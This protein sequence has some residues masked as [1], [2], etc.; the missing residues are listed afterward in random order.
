MVSSLAAQLAKGASLNTNALVEGSRRKATESYLFTGR[1]ADQHDLDTLHALSFNAF[2][3]LRSL[4]PSLHEYE[5]QLFSDAARAT[6][7]TLLTQDEV[8]RLD[9]TID[10]L[11]PLLGPYL[12]EGP[13]GKVLEWLVRRFRINEFNVDGVLALFLP[14]HE[15]P[16][17]AKMLSILHIKPNSMWSFLI[18][19]QSAAQPVPRPPLVT[20][21]LKRENSDARRFIIGLLP[22]AI[23]RNYVHHTLLAFNA[24]TLHD[25]LVRGKSVDEGTLAHLLPAL[26]E[27]LQNR[28][29]AVGRDAILGSY[30]LLS[31]LSQ[32]CKLQPQALRTIVHLMSNCA[33]RVET[34]QFVNAVISVCD[35][36]DQLDT[37][38]ETTCKNVLKLPNIDE[39]LRIAEKWAGIDKFYNPLIS[40]ACTRLEADESAYSVLE[41]IVGSPTVPTTSVGHLTALLLGKAVESTES[42][43]PVRRLLSHIAQIHPD[44]LKAI[45]DAQDDQEQ[46]DNLILTLSAPQTS[47]LLQSDEGNV[48]DSLSADERVRAAAVKELLKT[49][50][51]KELED[52]DLNSLYAALLTRVQDNSQTVLKALY[53]DEGV[54]SVM[55]R[56]ALSDPQSYITNL[57]LALQ[58][59]PKRQTLQLQMR[60]LSLVTPRYG[61]PFQED[62]FHR[63]VFPF[64]LFSKTRQHSAEVV[65]SSTANAFELLKGCDAVKQR[66]QEAETGQDNKMERINQAIAIKL[67]ENIIASNHFSTHLNA[68]TRKLQDSDPHVRVLAYLIV[69]ELLP[70]LEGKHQI[71]AA[72]QVI[73]A[74]NVQKLPELDESKLQGQ[75]IEEYLSD[76]NLHRMA[77]H[78]TTSKT[79]THWLQVSALALIPTISRPADQTIDWFAEDADTLPALYVKLQRVVYKAT[80]STS[81]LPHVTI[82]LLSLLF[83]HLKDDALAFLAGLCVTD[84]DVDGAI[85]VVALRHALAFLQAHKAE[86]DGVD[87]QTIVP[88]LIVCLQHPVAAVRIATL[89]CVEILNGLAE[90]KFSTVYA[91]D[92]IYGTESE[93]Q[94]Q[95]LSQA[96]LKRYLAALVDHKDH[97]MLDAGFVQVFHSQHLKR[98]TADKRKE[99]EYKQRILCYLLSHVSVLGLL[100]M[101]ISLLESL[102]DVSDSARTEVIAELLASLGDGGVAIPVGTPM[103]RFAALALSS[104]DASA[105]SNLNDT[106]STLWDIFVSALKR[107]LQSDGYSPA[108]RTMLLA[109][110]ERNLLA[111]LSIDRKLVVCTLLLDA[112]IAD[113]DMY[114]P[115]KRVLAIAFSDISLVHRLLTSI[116]PNAASSP[117]ASKRVKLTEPSDDPLPRLSLLAEVLAGISLPGSIELVSRLLETLHS[118]VQSPAETD[119]DIS[120]IEQSLMSAVEHVADKITEIPNLSPGTIH[121]D[122]LVELIRVADNPQTFNQA[123]LL[124]ATLARLAP[125]SV[126][127]NVMPV[128]TFMGSNVF[129]RDDSY[130][131]KVVQKTIDSIVPVM[132]SSLKQSY[133][134]RLDL[135]IASRDFLRVFTDASNHIP[136]HRRTHFFGHLVDVL[137][138]VDFLAPLCMLLTDKSANRIA[139]QSPDETQNLLSLPISVLHRHPAT[140]QTF[141]LT[142]ILREAQRLVA[143]SLD[144]EN[145]EPCV[146]DTTLDDEQQQPSATVFR[147]RAHALVVLAGHAVKTLTSDVEGLV[148]GTISNLVSLLIALSATGGV[149]EITSA[150][151]MTLKKALSCMP[152]ADFV[153]AVLSILKSQESEV[154]IGVLV[155]FSERLDQVAKGARIKV[156]SRINEIIGEI[157]KHLLVHSEGPLAASSFQA[158]RSIALT[159]APGEEGQLTSVVPFI[160]SAL[161]SQRTAEP[162]LGALAPLCVQLGPRLIPSFRDIVTQ[163][164]ALLREGFASQGPLEVFH[165]LL[166]SIP[167]FWSTAELGLVLRLYIDKHTSSSLSAFMKTVTKRAPT[168][169]LLTALSELWPSVQ[170]DPHIDRVV[171]YFD[172][173]KRALRG[174]AR[175]AVQ[176]NVRLLFKIFQEGFDLDVVIPHGEVETQAKKQSITAFVE[177]VVKLN[178]ASF[179]PLFRKLYDWAFADETSQTKRKLTFCNVYTGLLDYFKGLMNPY[180][181]FLL[182]SFVSTLKGYSNNKSSESALWQG[183]LEI[184][185]KSLVSDD[186]AFWRDDK[187]RLVTPSLIEQVPVCVRLGT[188]KDREL[189]SEC[190][191]ALADSATDD[192]L[193]KSLNLDLLMLTRSEDVRLRIF[194]LECAT[195]LWTAHG[196]KFLPF[197]SETTTFIAECSEDEHDVVVRESL[198]LKNVL[199]SIAGKITGL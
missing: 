194:A 76:A 165:G 11:L 64:L 27:P 127:H 70:R 166:T 66:A 75:S 98:S 133:S 134:A 41:C 15:S 128:F 171:G 192:T 196:G 136:R 110:L 148:D 78:K 34:K 137:G 115:S 118:I 2:R 185:A 154:Q 111:S 69:R 17:F 158:I 99:I 9:T 150:A 142:E 94:L 117:R 20:E 123:L 101:R 107:H 109:G 52:P 53:A 159:M 119:I 19:F 188:D 156:S 45:A 140:V 145:L 50:K 25:Y 23:K 175:P 143:R 86:S 95:Y 187:L 56:A 178:E 130:S 105:A 197:V 18:P 3:Q 7:R 179:R 121:L 132:V 91:F 177:L 68:L 160:L 87:F 33:R 191:V 43:I 4:S 30:I 74:I 104:F 8:A 71:D 126:L 28:T 96:D 21:L 168:P 125:D 47:A 55:V 157:R 54:D 147:K 10:S 129:H 58:G 35:A 149:E 67:A 89:D 62:I 155:L 82:G 163:C 63:L 161:K 122:I 38:N 73:E 184:F 81:R 59:K 181:S 84:R 164:T 6:D 90:N 169:V 112:G 40:I 79:T 180:M 61:A 37:F 176:D 29:D 44:T 151:R 173:L 120:Y 13:T 77:V 31:A 32:T 88:A 170:S 57:A 193:L 60:L 85:S 49:A 162:A 198:R 190:L 167:K 141:V 189:L 103:E 124:M 1:D 5:G 172:L 83:V 48:V 174:G 80:S 138:P 146:L 65:W 106:K 114:L 22:T 183:I 186:G 116:K 195:G 36:Q 42:S 131:F 46:I 199:E 93:A 135:Y 39:E 113:T 139:R 14:Y 182:P 16:H 12:P 108:C 153:D 152:V 51:S 144:S 72:N 92:V 97:I 100:S 26:I 102:R 24:A